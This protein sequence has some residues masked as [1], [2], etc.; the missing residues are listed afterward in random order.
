M[1]LEASGYDDDSA[2]IWK[3]YGTESEKYDKVLMES[4]KGNTDSTLN[5]VRPMIPT[6][7]PPHHV[8]LDWPVLFDS[9][10]IS[11][12]DLQDSHT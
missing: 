12:R 11:Y 1:R 5:F 6:P 3:L 7:S 8:V 9:R 4:W 10:L 2:G